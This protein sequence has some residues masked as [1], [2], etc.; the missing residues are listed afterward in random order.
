M[1]GTGVF[2]EPTFES[3]LINKKEVVALFTQ[4]DKAMGEEKASTRQVG[5]GMKTIALQHHIPIFQPFKINSDEG[6]AILRDLRPDLFVVAAYGQILSP[7]V[8]GVPTRG[9][10]NVHAS[11]LPKYRGAA[12]VQWTIANCEKETGV[13]I[14][15]MSPTLDGGN[16]LATVVTPVSPEETAGDLEARL[17]ILGATIAL[18]VIKK[19]EHG[20]VTGVPQDI[21]LATKAPKLRKDHGNINWELNALQI[22]AHIRAMQPWPTAFTLWKRNEQPPVRIMISKAIP[23]PDSTTSLAPGTILEPSKDLNMMQVVAGNGTILNV[24]EVQ[25]AGKRKMAAAEFLRGRHWFL[26][27][28]LARA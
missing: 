7:E 4:P 2:S 15:Q 14:I 27:D 10:I 24:L 22:S 19:M 6:L 18:E 12:P 25:P 20:P 26:G 13:S 8:L 17:S 21:S 9:G 3:L 1:M 28:S 5:K 16:I 23:A 11:L